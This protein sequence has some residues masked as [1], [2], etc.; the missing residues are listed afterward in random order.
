MINSC[1][2][3]HD[4]LAS[5][6]CD[7]CILSIVRIL[8]WFIAWS[9][10]F[11]VVGLHLRCIL[12]EQCAP[13]TCFA[14]VRAEWC[15]GR[16]CAVSLFRVLLRYSSTGQVVPLLCSARSIRILIQCLFEVLL[17][18]IWSLLILECVMNLLLSILLWFLSIYSWFLSID[19]D[20]L[21]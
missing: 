2:G 7:L 10:L 17:N 4:L 21:D 5:E 15:G 16:V 19:L 1:Y 11:G 13:P 12:A 14:S 18:S 9:V 8:E 6:M 3:F 20:L